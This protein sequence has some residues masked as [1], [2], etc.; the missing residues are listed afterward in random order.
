MSRHKGTNNVSIMKIICLPQNQKFPPKTFIEM[1]P[2]KC[3]IDDR[4]DNDFKITI[5]NTFKELN[6]GM[7]VR[8]RTAKTQS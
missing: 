1:V 4:Q 7:N 8:V 5:I 2:E 6:E 3:N